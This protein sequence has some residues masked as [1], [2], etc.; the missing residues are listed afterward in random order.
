MNE[1]CECGHRFNQHRRQIHSTFPCKEC[2]CT[3]YMKDLD[4]TQTVDDIMGILKA[5]D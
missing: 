4:D 5:A 3:D 1:P 2:T